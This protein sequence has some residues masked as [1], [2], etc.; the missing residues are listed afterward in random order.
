MSWLCEGYQRI[1]GLMFRN[2]YDLCV[3]PNKYRLWIACPVKPPTTT[4]PW[5]LT[6]TPWPATTTTTTTTTTTEGF[7]DINY[8]LLYN[9]YTVDDPRNICSV[10]WHIPTNAENVALRLYLDPIHVNLFTGHLNNYAGGMLKENVLTFW[11]APNTGATNEVGFNARGTGIRSNLGVFVDLRIGFN[12]WS[13]TQKDLSNA[14]SAGIPFDDDC[15][16]ASALPAYSDKKQ[17]RSL[18]PLKDTTSLTH[19]QTGIYIDPSGIAYRTI[20]IGAP[21]S[22]QEWVADNIATRHYRNGDPIL[23]VT[24]NAAWAALITGAMCTFNNDWGNV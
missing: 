6:T 23:E 21:G 19:G 5:P 4:T 9:W 12:V 13:S 18:R 7:E 2:K 1:H 20:A 15:F 8:G 11:N 16:T 17:G 14:A 3:A 10:G 22:V 24:G